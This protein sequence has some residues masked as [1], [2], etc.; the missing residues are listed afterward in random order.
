VLLLSEPS[1][2]ERRAWVDGVETPVVKA[3]TALSA[4]CVPAG[5]HVV[6][7]RYVPTAL[8]AG[9]SITGVTALV[10]IGATILTRRRKRSA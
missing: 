5:R 3:N 10:W 7:L 6:E 9:A 1:Y 8:M 4:I 2:P